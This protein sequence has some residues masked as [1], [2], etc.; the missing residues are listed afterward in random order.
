MENKNR[1]VRPVQLPSARRVAQVQFGL[2]DNPVCDPSNLPVDLSK[3]PIPP[4]GATS[5]EIATDKFR[6]VMWG[7][8][9]PKPCAVVPPMH[10]PSADGEDEFAPVQPWPMPWPPQLCPVK[11][12]APPMAFEADGEN[13]YLAMKDGRLATVPSVR[14]L[15]PETRFSEDSYLKLW[16]FR[17][18]K[19]LAPPRR[20][21]QHE[22]KPV[23]LLDNND[24]SPQQGTDMDV[25]TQRV[26]PQ[27]RRFSLGRGRST[28]SGYP[29]PHLM[30]PLPAGT[31]RRNPFFRY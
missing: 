18:Q 19:V 23:H 27:M 10:R 13:G 9:E 16:D 8:W 3:R 21:D 2:R 31:T 17:Q 25:L 14:L 26:I 12:D 22:E 6:G 20:I 4:P 28:L 15:M 24:V 1:S 11:L 29:R 7:E 5:R 30:P